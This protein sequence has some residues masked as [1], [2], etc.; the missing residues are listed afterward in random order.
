MELAIEGFGWKLA[1]ILMGLSVFGIIYNSFVT[2][3]E[4]QGHDRG[5]TALLVVA[6]VVVTLAA[7]VLLVGWWTVMV[8]GLLFVASGMPMI[9]GSIARYVSERRRDE[10]MARRLAEDSI[11]LAA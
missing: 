10:A 5:Y 3:L 8:I 1:A 9:L 2:W 7:A 11:D 6:G 4:R